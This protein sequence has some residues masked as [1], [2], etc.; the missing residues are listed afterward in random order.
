MKK[1]ECEQAIRSLCH[2]WREARGLSGA[3]PSELSFSDFISWLR[4]NYSQYLKFRTSTSVDYDA[5]MWFD[6]EFEQTWRR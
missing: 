3:P 2:N 6:Q 4:Q 1:D 5:E